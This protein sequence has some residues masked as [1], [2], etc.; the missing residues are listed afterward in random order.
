MITDEMERKTVKQKMDKVISGEEVIEGIYDVCFKPVMDDCPEYL[1]SLISL[2][3]GLPYDYV[4]ENLEVSSTEHTVARVT[5]RPRRSDFVVNIKDKHIIIEAYKGDYSKAVAKKN[6]SYAFRTFEKNLDKEKQDDYKTN[7]EIFEINFDVMKMSF[8]KDDNL[9][10]HTF[11][12]REIN[13]GYL[14]PFAPKFIYV[15][16]A[17]IS[18]KYYNKEKLSKLE[19]LV[20]LLVLT[21]KKEL[22]EV[23]KGEAI[24]EKVVNKLE[25]LS[26]DP[27]FLTEA[28]L[29]AFDEYEK[30]T[31]REEGVEEGKNQRDKEIVLKMH[32]KRMD[33]ET[34][35]EC[36][37]LSREDI[38]KIINEGKVG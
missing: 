13:N 28:E 24:M 6:L 38:E 34:I 37:G 9:T 35:I 16:L 32:E 29:E 17:K 7:V 1:A 14:H 19:R 5:D 18:K 30:K 15:D 11:E 12:T 21:S 8:I 2:I 25:S 10:I 22:R 4:L 20:L 23:S 36:T 3:L 31:L 33:I 27:I 26:S